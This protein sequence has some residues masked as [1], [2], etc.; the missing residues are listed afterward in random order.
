M[1]PQRHVAGE[2]EMK[3]DLV[4]HWSNSVFTEF[5]MHENETNEHKVGEETGRQQDVGGMESDVSGSSVSNMQDSEL[6]RNVAS[7][8]RIMYTT[9]RPNEIKTPFEEMLQNDVEF[10]APDKRSGGFLNSALAYGIWETI[11]AKEGVT[12]DEKKQ[13][14]TKAIIFQT[15]PQ[16]VLMQVA[17]YS[18]AKEVWDSIKVKHLGADLVQKARLQTL[19]SELETSSKTTENFLDKAAMELQSDHD[20][21]SADPWRLCT[22]TQVEELNPSS[23][24]FQYGQLYWVKPKI[25]IEASISQEEGL[26]K[27]SILIRGLTT[28]ERKRVFISHK[29]EI[30]ISREKKKGR[31]IVKE[32]EAWQG[33]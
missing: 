12:T 33:I 19:R 10:G 16:D 6:L 7:K 13:N 9:T 5:R 11:V 27:P 2:N 21:G 17:Q 4:R 26:N 15:L 30:D 31:L 29:K 28:K 22:V 25:P 3:E 20:K 24:Y 1:N 14:T 23:N 8:K 18:T 32:K